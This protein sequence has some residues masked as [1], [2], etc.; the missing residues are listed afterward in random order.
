MKKR[1]GLEC[2]RACFETPLAGLLSMRCFL[3]ATKS[4]PH[5]EERGRASARARV[6]KDAGWHCSASL[7][8]AMFFVA[9]A[10]GTPALAQERSEVALVKVV[11]GEAYALRDD[12]RS[13]IDVGQPIFVEDVVETEAGSLGLTFKD[14][15]RLSIG[16]NSRVQFTRFDYAP[17]EGRLAFV[18]DFFRGTLHYVSGVIAKLAP[19][20]VQVRTPVATVA[21]RGTRFLAEIEGE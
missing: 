11:D 9:I 16:P 15:S 2:R 6:S 10:A 13:A 3:R 19:E 8:L 21:V 18:I 20:A 7:L 14:G 12:A 4:A 1:R 17:A 5:P